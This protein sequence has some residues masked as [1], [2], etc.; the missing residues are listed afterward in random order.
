VS[1]VVRADRPGAALIRQIEEQ[2]RG[3]D[4][5]QPFS[6]FR[7]VDEMKR[8]AMSVERFQMTLLGTFAVVGLLLASAGIYG[9]VAYTVA[10][11]TREFG[12]RLALGEN[13]RRTRFSVIAGAMRVVVPSIGV[14]LAGSLAGSRWIAGLLYAVRPADPTTFTGIAGLLALVAL[15][16]CYLPARRAAR[17]EPVVALRTE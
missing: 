16:A 5:K 6:A 8:R 11:R 17:T 2:I 10:Q 3:V 1:W 12:I 13:P 15:L 4:P 14:G 7:S 9:L